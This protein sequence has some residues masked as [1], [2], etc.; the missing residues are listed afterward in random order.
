MDHIHFPYIY[1]GLICLAA[2]SAS[3]A[4][5]TSAFIQRAPRMPTTPAITSVGTHVTRNA[6]LRSLPATLCA[7]CSFPGVGS[8]ALAKIPTSEGEKASP[9]R[10]AHSSERATAD[11]RKADGTTSCVAAVLGPL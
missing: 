2:L 1:S 10:C 4:A 5:A 8:K 7:K 3:S 11:A 9:S 6:K